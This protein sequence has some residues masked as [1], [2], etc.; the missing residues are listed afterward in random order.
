MHFDNL[1][2]LPNLA[3]VVALDNDSV[4]LALLMSMFVVP[5]FVT[6]K[7][8]TYALPG[9]ICITT[10]LSSPPWKDSK[11][12]LLNPSIK[13]SL[14]EL[15]NCLTTKSPFASNVLLANACSI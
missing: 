1:N 15:V 4:V 3:G 2:L 14:N 9:D 13:C 11:K 8:L 10:L 12:P 7:P 5:S 6:S